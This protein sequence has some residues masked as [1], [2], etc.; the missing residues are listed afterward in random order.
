MD[1]YIETPELWSDFHVNLG[2]E[3]RAQLNQVLQPRYFARLAPGVAYKVIEESLVPVEVPLCVS[4]VEIQATDS[5]QP[6]TVIEILSPLSKQ[7]GH[8]GQGDYQRKRDDL[9]CSLVHLIEIDLLRGGEQP[10][11]LD[12]ATTPPASYRVLL[13]R[14]DHRPRAM[15]WPIQLPYPLPV[16]PIPLLEPDPD[17]PL[18]LGAAV[19]SVYERAAYAAQIDYRQPPP[20]PSL[21]PGEAEWVAQL[22]R[23]HRS[24]T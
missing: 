3:M 1:P 11:L 20:P 4:G 8:P 19:A 2:C 24:N 12:R 17:V 9:L 23:E 10:P 15:L 5:R 7:R 21:S 13:S 18:D 22:L 14:A 6:V 16:L